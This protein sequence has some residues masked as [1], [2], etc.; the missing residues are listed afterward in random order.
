MRKVCAFLFLG[1]L[2]QAA[3]LSDS[4]QHTHEDDEDLSIKMPESVAAPKTMAKGPSA[5]LVQDQVTTQ[6]G[7]F[8][9][10]ILHSSLKPIVKAKVNKV[11]SFI[12]ATKEDYQHGTADRKKAIQQKAETLVMAGAGTRGF[13]HE[14]CNNLWSEST[15]MAGY[16]SFYYCPSLVFPSNDLSG[17]PPYKTVASG[18]PSRLK[19]AFLTQYFWD[20]MLSGGKNTVVEMLAENVCYYWGNQPGVCGK[21]FVERTLPYIGFPDSSK[22]SSPVNWHC[23]TTTCIAPVTA[24]A[25]HSNYCLLTFGGGGRITEAIIPL[26][27][28]R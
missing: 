27:L 28:W 13:N 8:E 18:E 7:M 23:D 10:G 22:V 12:A 16:L 20:A 26:D 4:T 11:V 17:A 15:E 14:L 6:L 1:G 24:W 21:Q 25:Q 2:A 19:S 5:S 9:S 3:Q